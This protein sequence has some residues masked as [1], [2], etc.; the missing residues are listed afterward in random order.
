MLTGGARS[1]SIARQVLLGHFLNHARYRAY[2]D[3][4][5]PVIPYM[6]NIPGNLPYQHPRLLKPP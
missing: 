2:L 1:V 6:E 5:A 4:L 3:F